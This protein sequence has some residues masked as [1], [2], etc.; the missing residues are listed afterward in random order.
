MASRKRTGRPGLWL[1]GLAVIVV[2]LAAGYSWAWQHFAGQL[3][4]EAK[5]SLAALN[6]GPRQAD[7]LGMETNGYP[8]KLGLSCAGIAYS[9]PKHGVSVRAG[10]V[11]SAAAIYAP[12]K[13]IG[14]LDG[15]AL[16][17]VAGVE[18]LRIDWR[19]LQAQTRLAEP[20]P[21]FA[22]LA[23]QGIIASTQDGPAP[24]MTAAAA[25]IVAQP[26]GRDL[27]LALSFDELKLGERLSQGVALP[28][29]DGQ[30]KLT[31]ADGISLA[32]DRP[33]SLRG[34]SAELREMSI[35]SGD[36]GIDAS[37]PVAISPAGLINAELSVT[38]RRPQ[39][40]EA[41]LAKAFPELRDEIDTAF[42]SLT[43]LG[44]RPT[45]PL[46]IVDGNVFVGFIPLGRLPPLERRTPG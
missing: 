32:V 10:A 29:L 5:T 45:V 1:V 19:T 33:E 17:E 9:D 13:I 11:R 20:L 14:T 4:A 35:S 15:P 36:A 16:I 37:G 22:L 41:L 42:T 6:K 34:L 38:L 39:E 12:G 44:N 18:P 21:E 31:L 2:V 43:V 24:L 3:M 26:A 23:G 27:K 30:A 40:I 8:L 28:P 7:C 46:K 25:S